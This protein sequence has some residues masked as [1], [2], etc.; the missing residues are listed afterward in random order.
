MPRYKIQDTRYKIFFIIVQ[1][2][3]VCMLM[4]SYNT[5]IS[6]AV[7]SLFFISYLFFD[8][9]W[10]ENGHKTCKW[11][12]YTGDISFSIYLIHQLVI[13]V[14]FH[15]FEVNNFYVLLLFT[16]V[17]TL[18]VSHLTYRYIEKPFIA[19]ARKITTRE[20]RD[21]NSALKQIRSSK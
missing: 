13:R 8:R 19:L 10:S 9:I 21:A 2:L 16:L 15:I 4:L 12:A 17:I 7:C 1:V 20:R 6:F 11:L 5:I 14:L 3:F 18:F